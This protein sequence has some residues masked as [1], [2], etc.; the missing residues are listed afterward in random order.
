[1]KIKLALEYQRL[2]REFLY[3]NHRELFNKFIEYVSFPSDINYWEFVFILPEREW[4]LDVFKDDI[5]DLHDFE[6]ILLNCRKEMWKKSIN[7][8]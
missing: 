4:I 6:K 8:S 1:M 5:K 3:F 2:I 7:L